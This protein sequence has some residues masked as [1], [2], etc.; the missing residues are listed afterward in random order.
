MTPR[1]IIER[2]LAETF[3][4]AIGRTGQVQLASPLDPEEIARFDLQQPAP[5]PD[6]MRDLLGFARGFTLL[7]ERVDFRGEAPSEFVPEF[8]DGVPIYTDGVGSFWMAHVHPE[9]GEWAPILFVSSDP[10]VVVIQSRDLADFL[11]EL[12][13]MFRPGRASA[14]DRVYPIS[15]EIWTQNL[16][17]H[18]VAELR[19]STDQALRAFAA[20]LK[21][22]DLIADLRAR[23]IGSGFT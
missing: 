23:T 15:L 16:G 17:F 14:L 21:D 18:R 1:Q 9:T 10:P 3:R 11:E 19:S 2:A 8:A 6:V 7:G 12:F 22:E 5:L 13:N 20:S 4:D